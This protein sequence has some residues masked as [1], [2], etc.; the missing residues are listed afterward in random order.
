MRIANVGGRA[1]LVVAGHLVDIAGASQGRFGPSPKEVAANWAE[2]A[3]WAASA[4]VF[5]GDAVDIGRLGPALPDP[6][7]VFAIGLNYRGHALESGFEFPQVPP[8]FTKYVSSLTGPGGVI[9]LPSEN[10]DWEVELVVV[11]GRTAA[12][13]SAADAWEHVAGLTIGQDPLR[14]RRSEDRPRSAVLARQVVPRL[15]P[16]RAVHH[17]AGRDREPRGPRG[18]LRC[19]RRDDAE[20]QDQ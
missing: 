12:N 7:H 14:A 17:R 1:H 18:L 10:V 13:V 20:G 8:T 16:G 11:I 2:C 19:Q 15:R 6:A 5:G 4:E 9:S 3:A